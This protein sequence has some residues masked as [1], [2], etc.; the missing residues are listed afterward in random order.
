ME[1]RAVGK[2][3]L[4]SLA[5]WLPGTAAELGCARWADEDAIAEPRDGNR[6][7]IAEQGVLEGFVE[8]QVGIPQR[9]AARIRLLAVRSDRRR[10]GI[11]SRAVLAVEERLRRTAARCFV[12]VPAKLGLAFYFWL[13]LGYRPLNQR[14][15]PAS[16]EERE[17]VWMVRPLA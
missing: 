8:Y 1:L 12:L 7:L 2:D 10:L 13:R 5:E 15:W 17:A 11:G 4:A 16:P 6:L 3:D 9:D 14:E